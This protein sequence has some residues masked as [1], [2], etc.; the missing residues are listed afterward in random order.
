[1]K[2]NKNPP[3]NKG[4]YSFKAKICGIR[5]TPDSVEFK[6]KDTKTKFK[7]ILDESKVINF[8]RLMDMFVGE[9]ISICFI[10]NGKKPNYKVE[11]IY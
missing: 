3:Q 7:L 2:N 11:R 10:P 5:A 8:W 4:G 9:K 6:I 1:M